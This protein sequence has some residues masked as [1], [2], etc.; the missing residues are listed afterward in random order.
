MISNRVSDPLTVEQA[1]S[2]EQASQWQEAMKTEITQLICNNTWTVCELPANRK[3][4]DNKWVFKTK[5]NSDGSIERFKARL[6]AKGYSQVPV[7]DYNE[8]FA[9]VAKYKSMR[10]LLAIATIYNYEV[11]HLDVETAFLNASLNEELYMKLPKGY[12]QYTNGG[13]QLVCRLHKSIYGLKQASNEWNKELDNTIRSFGFTQ[14][15][16]EP[17]VYYR[18]SDSNETIILLIFVDDIIAIYCSEDSKEWFEVKNN[19]MNKYKMKDL[20]KASFVLGMKIERNIGHLK[21]SH[22]SH[23]ESM[24]SNFKMQDC[25][26]KLTPSEV[27]KLS[28]ELCPQSYEQ[29][30]GSKQMLSEYQSIVGALMYVAIST[31][32]DIM[33]SVCAVSKYVC[34]PGTAHMI[35]AKRVLR[36]LQGTTEIGL[37]YE[38]K[39]SKQNVGIND[40]DEH[41]KKMIDLVGYCDADWGGDLDDRRS[42][43]GFVIKINN[44]TVHWTSKRQRTVALS[45]AEAEYMAICEVSK[46]ITWLVSFLTELK[47]GFKTIPTVYSDNQSAIA[48]T[49]LEKFHNQSKHISI[50][51]HF[52][53]EKVK[54]LQLQL[55]YIESGKQQ[56]DILTKSLGKN[57]FVQFRSAIMN[58][59]EVSAAYGGCVK[60]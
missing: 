60:N 49:K 40:C 15:V 22:Q 21:L 6:V 42:T 25:K 29:E 17:C 20:K 16:T 59:A 37:N 58:E 47:F 23:I 31:R 27:S 1:L 2:S 12:E 7:I 30:K 39:Q 32:P 9:P 10:T 26:A 5:T 34:N 35:A 38:S 55:K 53:K 41:S 33:H 56:A 24:L 54:N 44:N 43:T 4:I 19:F 46:E 8:T 13:V 28:N 50:R 14:C 36:Y 51:Y 45:T 11:E 3:A 48:M 52:I 57:L 18:L